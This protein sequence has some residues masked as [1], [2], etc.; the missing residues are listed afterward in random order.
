MAVAGVGGISALSMQAI[1][2]MRGQLDDLQR[3]LGTGTKATSYAG[4]GLER[5]LTIGLRSHLA[6]ISGYQS[7]INQVGVRLSLMQTALTQF[8]SVSQQTKS[9]I[10]QSQ[11]KLAGGTQTQDQINIKGTLE[12]LVGMLNT[13]AD[14]RFL[15]S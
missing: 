1:A 10:L 8:D 5:G 12:S 15:F 2:D 14:G 4:L 9:K 13:S 11:Y 7:T 3:Q 6:S